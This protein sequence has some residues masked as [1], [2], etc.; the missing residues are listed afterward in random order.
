MEGIAVR[1]PA[2]IASI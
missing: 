1:V 2:P